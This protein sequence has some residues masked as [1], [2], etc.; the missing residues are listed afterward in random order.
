MGRPERVGELFKAELSEIITRELKDPRLG[1]V[2]VTGVD[3]SPD[4]K[5]A[6]VYVS[7]LGSDETK[8]ASLAALESAKGFMRGELGRRVRLKFLPE[9]RFKLDTT[10]EESSKIQ[11]L[12]GKIHKDH[13]AEEEP[14][15]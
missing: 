2:T 12:L 14:A 6:A 11:R 10:A 3:V 13:P 8:L 15:Q 1:F 4:L 7:V 9:L 5:H